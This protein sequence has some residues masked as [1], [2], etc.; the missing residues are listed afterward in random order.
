MSNYIQADVAGVIRKARHQNFPLHA[1]LL[2]LIDNSLDANAAIIE[3]TEQNGDLWI[4]D[5]GEGFSDI[6]SSL[7]VGK[8]SKRSG[9]GRYGV[10]LK[11]ASARYSNATTITSRGQRVTAPWRAIVCGESDG[12]VFPKEVENDDKTHVVLEDFRDRY[13]KDI[14]TDPIRRVYAPRLKSGDVVITL[15]GKPLEPLEKPDFTES[16]D[17]TVDFK[18][19]KIRLHGGIFDPSDKMRRFWYGYNPFYKGRLIGDGRIT[20]SGI[21]DEACSNFSFQLD[22]IDDEEEWV[23]ATNKDAVDDIGEAIEACYWDHTRPLLKKAAEQAQNIELRAVED[24]VNA[25]LRAT[26]NQ[27]RR[28]NQGRKGTIK[29]TQT[30]PTKKR[31]YTARGEG[32]YIGG[33][34][35]GGSSL[36]FK[37]VPLGGDSL[38]NCIQSGKGVLVEAN[39]DNKFIAQNRANLQVMHGLAKL[40]FTVRSEIERVDFASEEMMERIMDNAGSEMAETNGVA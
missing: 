20:S 33:N 9:I 25:L 2:E 14:C 3:V 19:R 6:V 27:T 16:I 30:G 13:T 18:G 1:A 26:G 23:L 4:T 17:E 12:E 38:G 39:Q 36:L 5:N 29:P 37:F 11:D 24:A 8:S 31:T 22:L 34:G 40:I 7:V 10:G 15:N 28:R 35:R 32:R 21:Q